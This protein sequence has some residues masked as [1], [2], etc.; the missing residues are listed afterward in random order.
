MVLDS[1]TLHEY[2]ND[3]KKHK[4]NNL[5]RN[6]ISQNDLKS[7]TLNHKL[8]QKDHHFF[9]HKIHEE[10][11]K[12]TDQK[13]SGRCWLFAV[14]NNLRMLMMKY[15]NLEHFEFSQNYLTFW[16][17]LE[18]CHSFLQYIK[19]TKSKPIDNMHVLHLLSNPISDG[20]QWNM[21]NELIQKYGAIPKSCMKETHHSNN[22]Y[23]LNS[24]LKNKLLYFAMEIREHNGNIHTMMKEIYRLLVYFLGEPPDKISWEY[25][26]K[27][28][29]GKT[30]K[31]KT[32]KRHK[33][34]TITI[35]N[36]KKTPFNNGF[37]VK[38]ITPLEFYKKYIP[39]DI[40]RK[41]ALIH[42]PTKPYYKCYDIKFLKSV[43]EGKGTNY[44]NVPLSV[45]K[46]ILNKS[47]ENKEPVWFGSDFSNNIS[48]K[49]RIMNKNIYNNSE[50]LQ[51]K[52]DF[53]KKDA[54]KYHHTSI[55]HA[56]IIRG[57]H[58]D[59]NNKVTK[60]LVENS[61][62]DFGHKEGTF[63][64][65]ENWVDNYVHEIVVDKDYVSSKIKNAMKKKPILLEPWDNFG[66]LL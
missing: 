30:K 13:H 35:K 42:N 7:I 21:I 44:V 9:N 6:V 28:A 61:H 22:T 33:K 46:N 31:H 8:I 1:K 52:L 27:K 29:G 20:G 53:S 59:K 40:S 54:I 60:Y 45:M 4:N 56:M 38:N 58:K 57:M 49:H 51:T 50:L 19:E 32:K 62:G 64:M 14:L 66:K 24:I 47:I 36:I 48:K 10:F 12:P 17:K 5:L 15:H 63:I 16:D 43:Y 41:I 65:F 23:N 2:K 39:I 11:I 55:N 34:K 25:K 37:S 18:K 3:Y 26:K